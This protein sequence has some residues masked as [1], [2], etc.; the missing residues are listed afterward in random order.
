VKDFL[1]YTALRIALFLG[2]LGIVLGVWGL[3]T[4]AVPLV[5]AVV[6]AFLVSGVASY[7]LLNGFRE[8]VARRVDARASRVTAR[9][10]ERRAREDAES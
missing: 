6:I 7:F 8:R 4:D 9:F 3:F 10:E 5:W 2:A 1:V